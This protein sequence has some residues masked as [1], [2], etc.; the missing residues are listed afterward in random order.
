M[1]K[2]D[3]GAHTTVPQL[4]VQNNTNSPSKINNN[5]AY[6]AGLTLFSRLLGF[7]RI[8]VISALYGATGT[9][10]LLNLVLSIPNN[11]RKLLAEGALQNAYMPSFANSVEYGSIATPKSSRLLTEVLTCFGIFT[12]LLVT[13]MSVFSHQI[14]NFLF[15][16]SSEQDKLLV[17]SLF[18]YIIYFLLLMTISSI[19]MGLLQT[20]K[21][22]VIPALSPV[23][24]SVTTIGIIIIAHKIYG[25]FAVVY[26]YLLGGF[27]QIVLLL[28][29]LVH[30]KYNLFR[31]IDLKSLWRKPSG[32]FIH[33]LKRFP[34]VSLSVV[35]PMIGQQIAFYL[36]STLP[37]GSASSFS[38]A[39][40]FWQL[41]I[42]V[43]I[44]SIVGVSF[45]YLLTHIHAKE[46]YQTQHC[47]ENA[48]D[49]L[50]IILL[51]LSV[52]FLFFS[53]PGIA[54]CLQRG[55]M[56]HK[57]VLMTSKVLSGYALGLFPMG[58]F[59]LFQKVFLAYQKTRIM[60]FYSMIFTSVDVIMSIILVRSPLKVAGLS[61]AYT[62]TL[63]LMV[64]IMFF[65]IRKYAYIQLY[66][67][68]YIAIVVALLP[69]F[70]V[71]YFLSE[72]T[73]EYW[74]SGSNITNILR[75][76]VLTI[77]LLSI[78]MVGYRIVGI[79]FIDSLR[80]LRKKHL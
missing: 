21:H 31:M 69:L 68:K 28:L 56:E 19:F 71:S 39:I 53:Y 8:G 35:F 50:R 76:F 3:R 24:M 4:Q 42:G 47:I 49:K 77:I 51:P 20:H 6:V 30:L 11:L 54:I 40:V 36:A 17:T 80:K 22:F 16:V 1:D 72:Y 12:L 61:W 73:Y 5:M 44:N 43:I 57:D 9:A 29:A 48:I 63:F 14:T 67:K 10:D 7:V 26:G 38:Y 23:L 45:T 64:P 13:M 34:L 74:K 41:P 78:I 60:F 46:I 37:H 52:L 15:D 33:I 62:I 66:I 58:L 25:A 2:D 18:S 79:N 32:E 59:L 70:F 55:L 75:F 27:L 65:H